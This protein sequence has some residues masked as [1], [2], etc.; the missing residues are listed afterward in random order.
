MTFCDFVN[1]QYVSYN[2]KAIV[3]AG[4]WDICKFAKN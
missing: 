1:N 4:K 3:Y 2:S